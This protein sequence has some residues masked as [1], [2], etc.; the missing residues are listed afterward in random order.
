MRTRFTLARTVF[1]VAVTAT[2]GFGVNA[3]SAAPAAKQAF[4]CPGYVD[5]A[6]QC[7][8]CCEQNYGG[9]GAWSPSTRYCHCAL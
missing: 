5:S 3:A 8:Y 9:Y 2:L 7:Q 6:E 4:A 1:G